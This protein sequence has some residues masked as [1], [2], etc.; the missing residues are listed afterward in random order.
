M[1]LHAV[2][3]L[4][5]PQCGD[6]PLV[7]AVV[8]ADVD[9]SDATANDSR[10]SP[11]C[12]QHWIE[13]GGLCC[14]GCYTAFPIHKGVP[15]LLTY[16]T[17]HA[18]QAMDAWPEQD[19]RRMMARGFRLARKAAPKGERLVG[20]SFSTEWNDYDYG[21]TLWTAPTA[22]RLAAFRGECGLENG[23]LVGRRFV[24]IGCGLGILTNEAATGLGAEAW[25]VDLSTAVF[26]AARHF[27]Q[28]PQVHF[29]QASVFALPFRAREFHFLYSHGVLHHTWSTREALRQAVELVSSGG[30]M[31]VW[32]YGYDDVRI[33][34]A[35]RFAFC[36]ESITRP[37]I[38]RM[39]ASL[40]T[41][42]L[43]PTIPAYKIASWL[44]RSSGT[45][46]TVYTAQQAI[47]AARDRFTPL[48]AHRHD[49]EEVSAWLSEM[50]F[51]SN[52]RLRKDEVVPSW[53]LAIER[54]VAIRATRA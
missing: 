22:D 41:A 30:R 51:H 29:V 9:T 33:S 17:P 36:F 38:S 35:R 49:F 26:R 12:E 47:H 25:G 39:P 11:T 18:E 15:V 40:A 19:R 2:E 6:K 44:G 52:H 34:P 27:R 46:G 24:E 14:D 53:G 32:L 13:S 42:F 16:P 23:A 31:Y 50:G 20:K 54:N 3:R 28:N 5:C 37:L 45:H 8:G 21:V 7:L 10:S 1:W 48:Y 4:A 43:W